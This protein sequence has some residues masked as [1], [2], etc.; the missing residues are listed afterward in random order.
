ILMLS[1]G[2]PMLLA[3]D[4]ICRTPRGNNNAYNQ[5]NATSWTDWTLTD[6][7]R[8]V[9]RHVQRM[10]ALRKAHRALGQNRFYSAGVNDPGLADVTGPGTRLDSS[11]FDDPGGRALACT[12]AGVNGDSDLHAMMNMFWEP[13]DFDMPLDARRLWQVAVDTSAPSPDPSSN[14]IGPPIDCA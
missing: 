8:D 11:G 9:L 10:I 13:L 5:D 7:K 1:R 2:V 3:G 12:I 14:V 6:A 4:E